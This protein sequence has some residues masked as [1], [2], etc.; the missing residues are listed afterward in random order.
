MVVEFICSHFRK[1]I[2]SDEKKRSI[3]ISLCNYITVRYKL[4]FYFTLFSII[5]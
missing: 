3:I 4:T 5:L 2:V 1:K